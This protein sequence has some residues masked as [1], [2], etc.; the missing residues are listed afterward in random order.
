[1]RASTA[2][3]LARIVA[4]F[5]HAYLFANRRANRVKVLVRWKLL[6]CA[7]YGQG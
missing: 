3:A 1:M 5:G 2:S 7:R 4:V 6:P